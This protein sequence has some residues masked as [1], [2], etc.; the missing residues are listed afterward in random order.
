MLMWH[1]EGLGVSEKARKHGTLGEKSLTLLVLRSILRLPK[2]R[3]IKPL[4]RWR[5]RGIVVWWSTSLGRS[6]NAEGAY[7]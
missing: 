3:M 6:Y 4:K 7:A 5:M 1:S 2:C